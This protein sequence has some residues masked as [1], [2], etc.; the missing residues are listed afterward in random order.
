MEVK[1]QA[2]CMKCKEQRDMKDAQV[3]QTAR[4]GFMA[5]GPCKTCGCGMCK[6]LSKA[7]AEKAIANKEAKKAY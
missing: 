1:M 4:G 6:I 5:K 3:V 2:R 7:D